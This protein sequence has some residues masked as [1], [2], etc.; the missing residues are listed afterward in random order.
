[1]S[2]EDNNGTRQYTLSCGV[3]S[4]SDALSSLEDN[5]GSF[6][7]G[8]SSNDFIL[9]GQSDT[10]TQ[11]QTNNGTIYYFLECDVPSTSGVDFSNNNSTA[12]YYSSAFNCVS[13]CD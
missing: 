7:Y 6:Y 4:D 3:A 9:W 13:F 10:Y 2:F 12:Y 5:N 1:V 11:P 8:V